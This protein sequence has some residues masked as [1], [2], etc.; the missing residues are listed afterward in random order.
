MREGTRP[1]ALEPVSFIVQLLKNSEKL[2]W[3]HDDPP[4]MP[5]GAAVPAEDVEIVRLALLARAR[6]VTG[7]GDLRDAVN[8]AASLGLE[9]ITP[10]EALQFAADS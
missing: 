4:D 6:I 1:K 9:A 3:E 7:D 5:A 2:A 10:A 8:G